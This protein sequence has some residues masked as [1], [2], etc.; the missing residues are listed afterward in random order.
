[1]GEGKAASDV[2]PLRP[3]LPVHSVNN[4]L[5]QCNSSRL[6]GLSGR[7]RDLSDAVASFALPAIDADRHR[8]LDRHT[9]HDARLVAVVV[10]RLMLPAI[11]GHSMTSSASSRNSRLKLRP[12]AL[13][14]LR[15][16]TSSNF[17]GSWTGR[18]EG[19][20]PLRMRST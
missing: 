2:P 19:L 1:M 4:G 10:D 17:V 15:L 5:L 6:C 7:C 8:P 9:A 11:S 3:S 13:A 20:A 16:T 14:V 12:S 18:S